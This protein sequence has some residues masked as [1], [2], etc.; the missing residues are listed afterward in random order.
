MPPSPRAPQDNGVF[1]VGGGA[2]EVNVHSFA[3]ITNCLLTNT[4]SAESTGSIA[5][6]LTGSLHM[7]DT[8][9]AYGRSPQV[10][11]L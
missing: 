7:S 6:A 5:V 2:L 4:S 8:T 11:V 9:I 10:T 3:T 1:Y